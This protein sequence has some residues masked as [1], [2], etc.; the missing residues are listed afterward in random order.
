MKGSSQQCP[1]PLP[2]PCFVW[3]KHSCRLIVC[4]SLNLSPD[5]FT[6]THTPS[7][8]WAP[9][10]PSCRP[11]LPSDDTFLCFTRVMTLGI[12]HGSV[13]L[14]ARRLSQIINDGRPNVTLFSLWGFSGAEQIFLTHTHIWDYHT[15]RMHFESSL[16]FFSLG[17][18]LMAL[19]KA[20]ITIL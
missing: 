14:P 16:W 5:S 9:E 17:V 12:L 8:R 18:H 1:W 15:H 3:L 20:N 2:P 19:V 6:L 11:V 10:T 7:T 13:L 4:M